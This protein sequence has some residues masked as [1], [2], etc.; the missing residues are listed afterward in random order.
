MKKVSVIFLIIGLLAISAYV[1]VRRSINTAGFQ[2]APAADT[3]HATKSAES[4]LDLRPQLIEKI[5]QLVKTGSNGLYNISIHELDPDLVNSELKIFNVQLTPDTAAIRELERT[6]KLPDDIFKINA[7]SIVVTGVG[8][9]E[10]LKKDVIDLKNISISS[11]SIEVFHHARPW[12]RDKREEDTSLYERLTKQAKKISV[13]SVNIKNG[14]LV[15]HNGQSNKTTRFNDIDIQLSDILIDSTTQFDKTRFLFAKEAELSTKNFTKPTSD[16]M[17]DMKIAG[18]SVSATKHRLLAKNISLQPRY[19]KQQFARK[20]GFMKERFQISIPSIECNMINW[21]NLVNEDMLLADQVVVHGGSVHIYLD[22]SLPEGKPKLNSF[23]SQLMMKLPL[24][25]HIPKLQLRNIDVVYEE[26]NPASGQ[27]GKFDITGL[28]GEVNNMTNMNSFIGKNHFTTVS[29]SA[30][31]LRSIPAH[32]NLRF[33]LSQYKAGVFSASVNM[34]NMNG[35]V[36]NTVAEP[37]GVFRIKRG[38]AQKLEASVAGNTTKTSGKVLLLYSDLHLTPL[39][40]DKN[41]PGKLGKKNVTSLLANT[42]L[43][44]NENPSG[45]KPARNPDC[46]FTRDPHDSFFNTLWK[47]VF[48]GILKTIGAPEKLAYE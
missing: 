18:I 13:E 37:L 29:A 8:I 31:I 5:Q 14:T 47:T 44:K 12:N 45:N 39:E 25:L 22:R 20:A 36:L 26:F 33:D 10:I 38:S 23:P 32:L 4:V 46:N 17:Y 15:S 35:D 9:K 3:A 1:Y 30:T 11:P 43:I 48:V 40:K 7:R 27:T 28:N 42:L 19:T 24:Q 41:T 21:W 2:P 16:N 34:S 6:A